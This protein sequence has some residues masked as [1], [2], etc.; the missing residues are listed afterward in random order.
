MERKIVPQEKPMKRTSVQTPARD[1]EGREQCSSLLTVTPPSVTAPLQTM[2]LR[3]IDTHRL[4]RTVAAFGP[5]S[6]EQL[7]TL[8]ARLR[9]QAFGRGQTIFQQGDRGDTLYLIAR[10][11]VRIYHP[12]ATGL[13]LTVVIYRAGDIF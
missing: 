7:T 6:N 12:S 13:E 11:Q 8:A 4:L 3:S 9:V 10:G 2:L 1:A 5:L